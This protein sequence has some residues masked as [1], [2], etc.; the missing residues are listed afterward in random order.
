MRTFAPLLL[1]WRRVQTEVWDY[2]RRLWRSNRASEKQDFRKGDCEI[3]KG[4]SQHQDEQSQN[5]RRTAQV[6]T[7]IEK[8]KADQMAN[9]QNVQKS[10][11]KTV[12]L[13]QDIK[14]LKSMLEAETGKRAELEGE[15]RKIIET[16]GL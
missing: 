9:S 4:Y 13:E 12:R 14:N 8:V 1:H 7:L 2:K 15:L 10:D 16:Q 5:T 6:A 11:E 3:T